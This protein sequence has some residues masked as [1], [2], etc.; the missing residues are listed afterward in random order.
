MRYLVAAVCAALCAL[1]MAGEATA[2][3]PTPAS[4]SR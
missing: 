2:T 1:T 4:G 3:A